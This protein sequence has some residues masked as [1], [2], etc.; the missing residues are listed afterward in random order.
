MDIKND[1]LDRSV[2]ISDASALHRLTGVPAFVWGLLWI[3][4]SGVVTM[5]TVKWSVVRGPRPE[6]D[7]AGD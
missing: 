1:V 5:L 6:T 2:A 7:T 3:G 4:V